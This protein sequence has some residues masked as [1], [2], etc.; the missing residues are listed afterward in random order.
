MNDTGLAHK[1]AKTFHHH[2]SPLLHG[3]RGLRHSLAPVSLERPVFVVGCSRGGT[4]LVYK[5]LSQA[6]ELGSLQRETHDFWAALH[7]LEARGWRS[8]VLGAGDAREQDRL[9]AA[10]L[11][12]TRT[13]RRRIVDK[14]NQ[15]GF[16][17]PY[18]H[19]LFPDACFVYVKRKPGDNLQSLI[20]GWGKPAEFG[21]WSETLP[22]QVR[23]GDG[24]YRRWCFFLPEGW[25]E[26]L[27]DEIESVC[28]FQYQAINTAILTARDTVAAANWVEFSYEGLLADPLPLLADVFARLGLDFGTATQ[29]RLRQALAVPYNAFS[30]IR[31]DKWREGAHRERIR[32]V[33]PGLALLAGRLGYTP[34]D[35]GEIHP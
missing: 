19:A 11:F 25:R 26:H 5:L 22:A 4:T 14:N 31:A 32:R 8:H 13:G 3:L 30:A 15:A 17:I 7:P 16:A 28:A 18:L 23:I 6:C 29:Q 9:A 34:T 27:D 35:T 33:L 10:R 21:T 1:L 12:Y 2:A 24:R 20:E